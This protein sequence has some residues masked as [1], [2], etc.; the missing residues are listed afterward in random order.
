MMGGGIQTAHPDG[1]EGS[2]GISPSISLTPSK[3]C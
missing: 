3:N 1:D 2:T